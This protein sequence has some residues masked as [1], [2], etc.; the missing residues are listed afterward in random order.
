VHLTAGA[1]IERDEVLS[2]R[3]CYLLLFIRTNGV[4]T[5]MKA[6]QTSQVYN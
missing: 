2:P 6:S 5:S 1:Q 3:Y 4:T